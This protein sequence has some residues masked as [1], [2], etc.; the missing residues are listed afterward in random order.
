M[1]RLNPGMLAD[2]YPQIQPFYR[3]TD[4]CVEW[5]I[6]DKIFSCMDE[7]MELLRLKIAG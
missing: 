4:D 5:A 6:T 7:M 2:T 3:H 1:N